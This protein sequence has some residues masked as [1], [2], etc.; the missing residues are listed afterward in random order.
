[1]IKK[2]PILAIF[3]AIFLK[4][5]VCGSITYGDFKIVGTGRRYGISF[6][7]LASA[8][9]LTPGLTPTFELVSCTVPSGEDCSAGTGQVGYTAV[10]GIIRLTTGGASGQTRTWFFPS[11]LYPG[12]YASS[13]GAGVEPGYAI[14]TGAHATA[15]TPQ[16]NSAG[17]AFQ[18]PLEVTLTNSDP[19]YQS[20]ATVIFAAPV[21]GPSAS[22][23]N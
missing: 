22:F 23:P 16:S 4:S 10:G 17:S 14:L 8:P 19:V 6:E 2:A 12:V 7:F 20:G 13:G 11:M 5:A 3:L 15:G 18:F 9:L 21:S 1:M